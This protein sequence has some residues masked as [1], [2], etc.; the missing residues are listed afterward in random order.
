MLL[1]TIDAPQIEALL[2]T[3]E[4]FED[5]PYPREH[6]GAML[7]A[8][9]ARLISELAQRQDATLIH[10]AG[11]ETL[12]QF[13]A[14]RELLLP[15]YGAI[16]Q[17][18]QA[19]W[20]AEINPNRHGP[21][22]RSAI[23]HLRAAFAEQGPAVFGHLVTAEIDVCLAAAERAFRLVPMVNGRELL[24]RGDEARDHALKQR[25]GALTIWT[26]FHFNL[27][28]LVMRDGQ[29][30]Y[31]PEVV[32][33]IITSCRTATLMYACIREGAELRGLF[34]QD[35]D[36]SLFVRGEDDDALLSHRWTVDD[37]HADAE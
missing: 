5:A 37:D 26:E 14:E 29:M 13:R 30:Q 12:E 27:L 28:W 33:E 31:R 22:G 18:L 21:D 24:D 9:V 6:A 32:G 19:I 3:A 35:T 17:A 11:A 7:P 25:F 2:A 1:Q 10:L 15:R 4:R 23:A 36:P 34:R 20:R 8:D 16:R